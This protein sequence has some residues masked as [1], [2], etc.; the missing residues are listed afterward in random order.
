MELSELEKQQAVDL[1][2]QIKETAK[3]RFKMPSLRNDKR[4]IKILYTRYADDFII[5]TNGKKKEHR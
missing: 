3:T 5:L 4:K 2:K 1:K